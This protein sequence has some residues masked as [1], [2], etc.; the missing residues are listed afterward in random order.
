MPVEIPVL[1]FTEINDFEAT[2]VAIFKHSQF[3]LITAQI[4]SLQDIFANYNLWD[5]KEYGE[6]NNCRI[7]KRRREKLT[8]KWCVKTLFEKNWNMQVNV[9]ANSHAPQIYYNGS[10]LENYFCSISHSNNWVCGIVSNKRVGIDIEMQRYFKP[11]LCKFF[12]S[13]KEIEYLDLQESEVKQLSSLQFFC[14]KEAILKTLGLGI[15]GGPQKAN[16]NELK[17][18]RWIDAN[19]EDQSF[20]VFFTR[21]KQF[22]LAICL[23]ATGKSQNNQ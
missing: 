1:S 13:Q 16:I 14:T 8:G 3:T 7:E 21:P 17:T 15:A 2:P 20:Q 9:H 10:R 19:Y 22:G 6:I 5:S 18:G 12:C 11:N 23:D 4:D